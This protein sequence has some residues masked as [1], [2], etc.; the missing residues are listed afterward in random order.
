MLHKSL[1]K[2]PQYSKIGGIKAMTEPR[3]YRYFAEGSI[4]KSD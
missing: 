1:L 2:L 4:E 3:E